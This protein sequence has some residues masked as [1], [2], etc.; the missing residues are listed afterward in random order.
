MKRVILN[1]TVGI[2]SML[3]G[4]ES[5]VLDFWGIY[6][7]IKEKYMD[8]REQVLMCKISP[9]LCFIWSCSFCEMES[10]L[11]WCR[12]PAASFRT[13]CVK[14]H[15]LGL[16]NETVCLVGLVAWTVHVQC[17]RCNLTHLF[18]LSIM[19][20]NYSLSR[21]FCQLYIHTF[22]SLLQ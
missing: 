5:T 7:I 2:I 12:R 17:F 4:R 9:C 13:I 15:Q 10:R 21:N 18:G 8:K 19:S 20:S 16:D 6:F 3:A 11:I 22:S 14:C 1:L